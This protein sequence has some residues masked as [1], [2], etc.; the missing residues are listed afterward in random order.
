MPP[1][2]LACTGVALLACLGIA[3]WVLEFV[4]NLLDGRFEDRGVAGI[5][6]ALLAGATFIGLAAVVWRLGSL[7]FG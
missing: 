7:I 4:Q 2:K 6:S 3:V 5:I 1:I